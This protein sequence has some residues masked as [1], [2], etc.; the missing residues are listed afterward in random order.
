M[1]DT[2]DGHSIALSADGVGI[3]RTAEPIADFRENVSLTTA[4]EYSAWLN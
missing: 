1:V 3:P 2:E 4:A